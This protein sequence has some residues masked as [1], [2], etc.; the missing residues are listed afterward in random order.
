MSEGP[1]LSLYISSVNAT[2]MNSRT[3]DV[4]VMVWI[5]TFIMSC[6]ILDMY[7]RI[8]YLLLREHIYY[9]NRFMR[10]ITKQ[11]LFNIR[12]SGNQMTTTTRQFCGCQQTATNVWRSGKP[13]NLWRSSDRHYRQD[14]WRS[15]STTNV[16]RSSDRHCTS[17]FLK[18]Y[19]VVNIVCR[20]IVTDI[21]CH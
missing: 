7:G 12:F 21:N 20:Y 3:G 19:L 6:W 8:E 16:Q 2:R 15:E 13:T 5:Y 11:I 14:Q 10:N 18:R 17:F 1:S 9:V 4:I